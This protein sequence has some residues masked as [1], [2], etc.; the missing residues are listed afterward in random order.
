MPQKVILTDAQRDVILNHLIN[1][2]AWENVKHALSKF[3][4]K[5]TNPEIQAKIQSILDAK[6]NEVIKRLNDDI[7][8]TN[9]EFPN[10]RKGSEFLETVMKISAVYDSIVEATHKNPKDSQY[11]PVGAANALINDLREYV[12]KFLDIDLKA[13]Y[14]VVN[15]YFGNIPFEDDEDDWDDNIDGWKKPKDYWVTPK[16]VADDDGFYSDLYKDENGVRPHGMSAEALADWLNATFSLEIRNGM[17]LIKKRHPDLDEDAYVQPNAND[18]RQYTNK[19]GVTVGQQPVP[20]PQTPRVTPSA[21]APAPQ[22]TPSAPA[23]SIPPARGTDVT[24]TLQAKRGSGPDFDSSKMKS[25]DVGPTTPA[26][27]LGYSAAFAGLLAILGPIAIVPATA[28]ALVTLLKNKGLRQ[29]RAKTLNDLYQSIRDIGAEA[30]ESIETQAPEQNVPRGTDDIYNSIKSLFQNIVNNRVKLGYRAAANTGTGGGRLKAGDKKIYNNKA[31]EV[32]NPDSNGRVQVKDINKPTTIFTVKPQD[33][34]DTPK[35]PKP[36][37]LGN[38]G[39]FE[40]ELMN[41]NRYIKDKRTEEYLQKSLSTD[42]VKAFEEFLNRIELIR[43]KLKKLQSDDSVLNGMIKQLGSNPIIATNFEQMFNIS[44]DKPKEVA[45]LK[46]F[47]NDLFITVYSSQYKYS[48]MID[49]IAGLGGNIN[50]LEEGLLNE[51]LDPAEEAERAL[52]KTG[53]DIGTAIL[54]CR[55]DLAATKYFI[56]QM[57]K[58]GETPILVAYK[59]RFVQLIR[60]LRILEKQYDPQNFVNAEPYKAQPFQPHDLRENAFS[61]DAQDRGRFKNN[62]LSFLTSLVNIFQYLRKTQ[63]K[64]TNKASHV[65]LPNQ[66]PIQ[67]SL[68]YDGKKVDIVKPPNV[69]LQPGN[70]EIQLPNGNQVQ[71]D[72][73]QVSGLQE[74]VS[75][76]KR[77]KKLMNIV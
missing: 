37:P 29:S 59:K 1:E 52:T 30:P 8:Q 63:S 12:K 4:S 71:V 32:M 9:P 69:A 47:I 7:Q 2:G 34:T 11:L 55:E 35:E 14:S 39:K 53:G 13:V 44:S 74:I 3:G 6:G 76:I 68:E 31:V 10:N 26:K 17:R 54:D 49:K 27:T 57:E 77:I 41:E 61:A 15:E 73:K 48:S 19:N 58:I 46:N 65:A 67:N 45:S 36:S 38:M 50:K 64:P 23:I 62:L 70:V 18:K 21:T 5:S 51:I 42:K 28:G 72:K 16:E 33:L 20:K 22:P 24:N 66:Q 75:E 43:N 60:T 25:L 40:S 56:G